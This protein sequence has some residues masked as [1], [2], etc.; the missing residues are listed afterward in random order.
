MLTKLFKKRLNLILQHDTQPNQSNLNEFIRIFNYSSNVKYEAVKNPDGEIIVGFKLVN[1]NKKNTNN[2]I[3][4]P[5]DI[6]DNPLQ[7]D[8]G[9]NPYLDNSIDPLDKFK[10]ELD[11][12]C[13][14]TNIKNNDTI[15]FLNY[16]K[17]F[18]QEFIIDKYNKYSSTRSFI[19]LYTIIE[20]FNNQI[21]I[22]LLKNISKT[23]TPYVYINNDIFNYTRE[24]LVSIIKEIIDML[25][26]TSRTLIE[27]ID[28]AYY[29]IHRISII[30]RRL[31]LDLY[32]I[33]EGKQ[34][35]LTYIPIKYIKLF[36]YNINFRYDKCNKKELLV[37]CQDGNINY[38]DM[39][40][41]LVYIQEFIKKFKINGSKKVN[42]IFFNNLMYNI[43]SE[44]IIPLYNSIINS[45]NYLLY[46][47]YVYKNNDIINYTRKYLVNQIKA[48]INDLKEL[49]KK[50]IIIKDPNPAYYYIY[51][52]AIIL[53]RLLFDLYE[54]IEGTKIILAYIKIEYIEIFINKIHSR[55]ECL[56]NIKGGVSK[57]YKKT[58]NKITVLYKKKKYTRNIHINER[59]KYVK[60]NKTF[61]LLSKL[62]KI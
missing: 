7:I 60:I 17:E 29:Y 15:S 39:I 13:R 35:I 25:N 45:G 57:K 38:N 2:K 33:I 51:H 11:L 53:R 31:L 50:L 22:E 34:I 44:I 23:D 59:K 49:S 20:N 41:F 58:N 3:P 54:I 47:K 56:K 42:E 1:N 4:L 10:Q 48:K 46:N 6:I 18:I 5:T 21:I 55:N 30:L 62:K 43:N 40:S 52:I 14:D 26:T 27:S 24:Y 36:I 61:I 19:D 16:I 32:D 9:P 8:R 37:Q 28:P 12:Y